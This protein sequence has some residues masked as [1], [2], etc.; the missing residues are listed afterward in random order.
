M[1]CHY[2]HYPY[3]LLSVTNNPLLKMR[4]EFDYL[5]LIEYIRLQAKRILRYLFYL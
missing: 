5:L 2:D 4:V 1:P 3:I